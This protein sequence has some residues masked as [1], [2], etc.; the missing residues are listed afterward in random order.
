MC[1]LLWCWHLLIGPPCSSSVCLSFDCENHLPKDAKAI[2]SGLGTTDIRAVCCR[3]KVLQ[4]FGTHMLWQSDTIT[5]SARVQGTAVAFD[6][7]Q[8]LQSERGVNVRTLGLVIRSIMSAA[9]FLY[10]NVSKARPQP[11]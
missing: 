7:M 5:L 1:L 9:K 6:Y 8:W 10:H 11:E 3:D 2:A 4:T